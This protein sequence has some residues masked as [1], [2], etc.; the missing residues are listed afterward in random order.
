MEAP[1][2][3]DE[4]TAIARALP[5]TLLVA[6][7]TEGGKSP[8]LGAEAYYALGF[9]MVFFSASAL[10]ATMQTLD[11]LYRR[12][13]TER[14]TST[15]LDIIIGFEERNRILGLEGVYEVEQK[16]ATAPAVRQTGS[17]KEGDE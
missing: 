4:Y 13:V 10:R 14:T 17:C 7:V 8:A 16:Y 2:A 9:R 15:S 6:D 1:H 12:I 11:R 3:Q 5:D